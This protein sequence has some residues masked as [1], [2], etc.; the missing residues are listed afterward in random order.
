[1]DS[2]GVL[3]LDNHICVP[4]VGNLQLRV[5]QHNHDH[6]VSGHFSQNWTI[7]LVR[8]NY[9]WSELR[10][11]VRSYVTSCTTCMCLKPQRHHPYRLLKQ[12][13]VPER[14]WNSISMDFIE[15]LPPSS[16]FD[17]IL[18][19]RHWNRTQERGACRGR[20]GKLIP[21]GSFDVGQGIHQLWTR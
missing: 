4:D 17:T 11:S 10:N 15:K 14:P 21:M 6:P 5:L 3:H 13:L 9:V 8:W 16:G 12:L 18:V 20:I 7:D 2:E 1:M 19:V